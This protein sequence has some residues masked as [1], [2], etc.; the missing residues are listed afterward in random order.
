MDARVAH[1]VSYI[2]SN[3]QR[4]LTL[5]AMA[6][7]VNLSR[8]RFCHLFKGDTGTSPERFLTELRLEKAKHILETEFLTVKE[9]MHAVGM[10]DPSYFNRTF[11]TAYGLTPARWRDSRSDASKKER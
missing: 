11:K 6:A 4:K 5:T 9:V 10:S 7:M 1:V 3:Y 2:S 8:W